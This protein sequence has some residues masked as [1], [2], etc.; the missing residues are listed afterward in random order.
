MLCSSLP[1]TREE[2]TLLTEEVKKLRRRIASSMGSTPAPDLKEA[3]SVSQAGSNPQPGCP[4]SEATAPGT[5]AP[6]TEGAHCADRHRASDSRTP[7][8]DELSDLIRHVDKPHVATRLLLLALFEREYILT[9]S[10]SG[11]A[12]NTKVAAKPMFDQRLYSKMVG[13]LKSKF[14]TMKTCDITSKVHA[15]QKSLH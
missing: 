1:V 11:K 12:A 2:F 4:C 7:T 10:V 8:D 5:S 9:H 14:P 3:I 6:Q 15:V 13:T